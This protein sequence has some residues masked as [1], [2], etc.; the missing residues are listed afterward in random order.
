[1]LVKIL[2]QTHGDY[3]HD[4][5]ERWE[6][7]YEGGEEW[8]ERIAHF[9]PQNEEEPPG[10]YRARQKR[11]VY[12]NHV[13]PLADMIAS[14]LLSSP[15]RVEGGTDV[16]ATWEKDADGRGAS[17]TDVTRELLTNAL[18]DRR[19][20]AWVNLPSSDG[21]PVANRLDQERAGL[22]AP[23]VVCVEAE[24]VRNWHVD[25]RGA[26]AAVMLRRKEVRQT[27]DDP[28]TQPQQ[29]VWTWI[30][31]DRRRI[32][33]W[34]WQATPQKSAP[35]DTDDAEEVLNIEHKFGRLPVVMLELP[36]GLHAVGKMEAPATALTRLE[37]DLDWKLHVEAH[38]L[39]VVKVSEPTTPPKL[40]AGYYLQIGASDDVVYAESSGAAF[41][42]LEERIRARKDDLYRVVQ[43]MA[44][45]AAGDTSKASASAASKA[46]DWKTL[47][48]MLE[49]YGSLVRRC[50]REI[51]A[52]CATPWGVA[53]DTLDV[54]G[55]GGWGEEDLSDKLG[56]LEAASPLVKSETFRREVAKRVATSLLD[57]VPPEVTAA[58]L[59]EI[60]EAD[61]TDQVPPPM[62]PPLGAEHLPAVTA[63]PA[64]GEAQG[65]QG[66][67]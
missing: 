4:A 62:V 20:F 11:A 34:E 37:C 19:A 7:L 45:A 67:A 21:V 50:L 66:A 32:R 44:Q 55:M 56:Q 18:R 31:I 53:P 27:G 61:Y 29:V 39:L 25:D 22:L 33:R 48:V 40:G 57:D 17:L 13:G 38:A 36:C 3:D 59:A 1:M 49:A 5:L 35:T 15:P 65:S 54:S 10:R 26:L 23:Y 63:P 30:C 28:L 24:E 64:D 9:I 12:V 52:C 2:N 47:E 16:T 42:A 60:D 46:L 8:Q 41:A 58:I 14:W 6:A 43:Q 51:L